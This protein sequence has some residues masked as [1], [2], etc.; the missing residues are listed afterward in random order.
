M[1]HETV[2]VSHLVKLAKNLPFHSPLPNLS[3]LFRIRIGD[4]CQLAIRV[5]VEGGRMLLPDA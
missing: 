5:R 3:P 2:I 1:Q 4:R